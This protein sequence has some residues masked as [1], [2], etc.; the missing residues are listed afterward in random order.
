MDD[1]V[2][3]YAEGV[4]VSSVCTSLPPEK[5]IRKLNRTHPTGIGSKWQI[6]SDPTFRTGQTNPCVCEKDPDRKHYLVE[7]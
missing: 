5:M 3:V 2:I 1:T 6:S 7:C 4:L